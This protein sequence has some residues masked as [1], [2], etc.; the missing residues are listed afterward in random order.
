[1]FRWRLV[2][3]MI[4]LTTVTGYAGRWLLFSG[5]YRPTEPLPEAKLLDIHCHSAGIGAGNSGC[6]VS[7]QMEASYKFGIYLRSFGTSRTELEEKGDAIVLQKISDKLAHSRHVGAA[8]ILALDGAVNEQGELDR[9]RTEVYV[10][11]EFVARETAKFTNRAYP[12]C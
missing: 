3:L 8:V 11:N 7:R 2:G 1:M 6:F 9:S 4:L 12:V 5:P 10:P